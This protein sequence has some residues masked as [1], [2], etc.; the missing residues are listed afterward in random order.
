LAETIFHELGH[1]RVFARGDTDF[2]EAFATTVGQEG[3]R[4]WL[5]LQGD[6]GGYEKYLTEIRHT[7][8][9][10]HLI[11]GARARLETLYGDERS[12]DGKIK[13]AKKRPLPVEELRRE[14]QKVLEQLRQDYARLKA[15]WGGDTSY[16]EWFSRQMNN[17]KLNSVAAYYDLVPAFEYLLQANNG[18]MEKFYQAVERLSKKP[19][20]ERQKIL[21]S[22]EKAG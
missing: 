6:N 18:D 17:A 22:L 7:R 13:A 2:N 4:R 21:R 16:D 12:E 20:K 8:E 15:E 10:A 11:A 9:F 1:Q 19:K 5:R 3:A 14:K